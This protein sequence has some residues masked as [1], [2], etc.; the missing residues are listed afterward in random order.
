MASFVDS[1]SERL[2]DGTMESNSRHP[3]TPRISG[4]DV[5]P[6]ARVGSEDVLVSCLLFR[7]QV[8]MLGL[9]LFY[10][11]PGNLDKSESLCAAVEIQMSKQTVGELV[12]VSGFFSVRETFLLP[13]IFCYGCFISF[14]VSDTKV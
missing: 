4:P 11:T 6:A 1:G 8:Y 9:P 3:C 13:S 14:S 5:S 12:K 10:E 7:T 2:L